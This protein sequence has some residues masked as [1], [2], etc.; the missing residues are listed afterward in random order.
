[1]IRRKTIKLLITGVIIMLIGSGCF[2]QFKYEKYSSKDP[3]LG[4]N[5]KYIAGWKFHEQ[6]G[7]YGSFAQVVFH[8]PDRKDKTIKASM[9]VTVEDSSKVK[10]SPTDLKGMEEDL[11]GKRMKLPEARVVSSARKNFLG[12]AAKDIGLTY[13]APDKVYSLD[14]KLVPLQERIIIFKKDDKFYTVKYQNTPED[15]AKFNQAFNH[16]TKTLKIKD[17]K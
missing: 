13:R 1:M 12:V 16:I 2:S 14:A 15:F 17:K 6:K 3:S 7:A 4:I 8:E 10:F 5:I 11:L 9:S